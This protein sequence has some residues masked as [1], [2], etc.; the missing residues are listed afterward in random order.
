MKNTATPIQLGQDIGLREVM[1]RILH[2]A[3]VEQSFRDVPYC[4]ERD[5]AHIHREVSEA[6]EAYCRCPEDEDWKAITEIKGKPEGVTVEMADALMRIA[7][8]CAYHELPLV[9]AIKRKFTYLETA[10]LPPLHGK[11][12]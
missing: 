5:I 3:A 7:E 4:M 6:F 10:N 12:F 2:Y 1:R 9:E 11:R 8:F